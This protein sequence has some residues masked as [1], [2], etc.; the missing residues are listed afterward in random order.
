MAAIQAYAFDPVSKIGFGKV[1]VVSA[2]PTVFAHGVG[3]G[4]DDVLV[5]MV[6]PND[7]NGVG[8]RVDATDGTNVTITNPNA[9]AGNVNLLCYAARAATRYGQH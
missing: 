7:V 4:A 9:G 1:P 3:L 8:C 6:T 2:G 5:V